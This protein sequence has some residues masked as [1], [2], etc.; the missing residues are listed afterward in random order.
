M[1]CESVNEMFAEFFLLPE[2]ASTS[3]RRVDTLMLFMLSVSTAI[4]LSIFVA[5]AVFA[6]KYRRRPGNERPPRIR[7]SA[8]LETIWSVIPTLL[9]LG[10]FVWG[11]NVYLYVSHPPAGAM[12]VY[13]VAKQWMWKIQHPEGQREINELHVPVGQPVKVTLTS[14]DVIHSFFVPA[15]RVKV[16]VLPGRY[17]STWFEATK[18]GRYDL[19]CSQYCGVNHSGMI[20]TVIVMKPEEYQTWLASHAEGSIALEGRKLFLKY[21]CVSCHSADALARAPVLENL[22]GRPV[23]LTDGRTVVADADYLRKSIVDPRGRRGGRLRA[24]HA[25]VPGANQRGGTPQAGR[26]HQGPPARPNAARG[27]TTPSRPRPHQRRRNDPT[28]TGLA[29]PLAAG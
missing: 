2:Q 11:A 17:V 22:Y 24:D 8:R 19:F 21:Q 28:A 14:E 5:I 1:G 6:V 9:G 7:G 13:V 18:P 20:G 26:L 27:S 15:F 23:A 3:A 4:A 16:D 25:V 10:M 29:R 12:E